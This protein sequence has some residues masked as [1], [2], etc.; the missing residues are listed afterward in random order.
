MGNI[1]YRCVEGLFNPGLWGKDVSPL[2]SMIE[3]SIKACDIDQRR[4]LCKNI[5][6]S[7]GTS[8]LHGLCARL[9]AEL[10]S[11]FPE[12]VNI[13][14]SNTVNVN[15]KC[16]WPTDGRLVRKFCERNVIML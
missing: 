8:M 12:G 11:L 9:E 15:S 7:G 13:K 10:K 1:K 4:E 6:L 16:V 2:Q 3:R 5:Y 14:V